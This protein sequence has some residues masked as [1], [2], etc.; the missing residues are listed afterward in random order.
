[1]LL[2]SFVLSAQDEDTTFVILPDSSN[3]VTAS[4]LVASPGEAIYSQLGHAALRMECPRFRLDYCFSFEE[5]P[6]MGGILKFFLGKTDAHMIAVPTDKFLN[7]FKKE[8]RQVKQYTLNLTLHEEQEL[9][10]LLDMDYVDESMRN[11]NFLQNNCSSVSLMAI[12]NVVVDETID[13]NWPEP[14]KMNNGELMKYYVRK[15]PWLGFWC[16]SFGGSETDALWENE[17][18]MCPELL[19]QV[20]K[21]ASI[22]AA[23]GSICP[24]VTGEKELLP[25]INEVQASP[26]TPTWAFGFLLIFT[27]LITLAQLKWKLKWLPKILDFLLMTVVT[28]AGLMLIYTSFVSGLFGKHWNWYLITFNPLP[29]IIWL[30]WHKRKGFYK[31]YLF[32]TVVL[33]L[34]IFATPLSQQLDLPHQLITATLA[35][36]CLY[37]YIDCKQQI[38]T[39]TIKTKK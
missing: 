5:E 36:R 29:L 6:G 9:W 20:L 13:F 37:N 35:V 15:W 3:F 2:S 34:F 21:T 1:M 12:E 23:D 18:R 39:T 33:V 4:L 16:T 19:P 27:I 8:G 7:S 38:A 28:L 10:R 22:V 25:L 26:V 14:F 31:I 32:Y 11:F 24:M 30:I 17:Q